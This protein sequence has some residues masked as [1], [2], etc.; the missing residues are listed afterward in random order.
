[1]GSY[2]LK[3]S[4]TALLVL[5]TL[6]VLVFSLVRWI[7]GD[8]VASF[9]DPN[10]PDPEQ[11]AAI[12]HSLGLDRSWLAQ[13]GSWISEA[14]RGN[15]G[16]SI[17]QPYSVGEQ[18]R[19]RLPVSVELGVL[20]TL[21]GVLLGVPAGV[22]S[23]VWRGRLPDL[24]FRIGSFAFLAIPAFVFGTFVLLVNSQTLRLRLI[25]YVPFSQD[26]LANLQR[27]VVPS[28]LLG[29]GLAALV[30]RYVRGTLLDTLGQDYIR[31]GRSKGASPARLVIRHALR[32]A[33]I[34][35]TTIV[36]V[37]LA[38][39][40]GGTVVIENVFALP[41]MGNLLITAITTTDYPTIQASIL[42]IGALYVAI[43]LV[44][45]LLYPLVDPRIRVVR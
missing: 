44:V 7:P 6:S 11:I 15:F 12:R 36:G 9:V 27:M 30:C 16:H 10:N 17:T 41:G 19:S 2:L 18:I 13:Y 34:P 3:R 40:V 42:V 1:V 31:T 20:A 39:L 24:V 21:F 23:A 38:A 37:Q 28:L 22:A 14:V 26:P 43:N 32:N 25:G 35:V 29:L 4:A 33:L 8:P 45:D 5:I